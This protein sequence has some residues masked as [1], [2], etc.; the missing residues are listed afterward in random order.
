MINS[1]QWQ[2]LANFSE[3]NWTVAELL[4]LVDVSYDLDDY[5][6]SRIELQYKSHTT[7]N[8]HTAKTIMF[9]KNEGRDR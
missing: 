7:D 3:G 2:D 9:E 6:A 5:V 8:K 4:D 1:G